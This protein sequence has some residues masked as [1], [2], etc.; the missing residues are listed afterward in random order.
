MKILH[1]CWG[2]EPTNGAANIA[3]M[4]MGEQRLAGHVVE[5]ASRWTREEIAG[6]DE[7]WCHC[8]WYWR[9]W[10]SVWIAKRLGKRIYWVPECCYDPIRLAHHG[11]KKRLAGPF[12][13]WAL[14]RA[15]VLVATCRAEGE[16]IRAYEPRVKKVE[17]S[18][19]RR[20]FK[21]GA[22]SGELLASRFSRQ[23]ADMIFDPR[24]HA[25]PFAGSQ[26]ITSGQENSQRHSPDLAP[27]NHESM[28]VLYLGRP[29][30]LKGTK[31]LEQ[32]VKELN[33]H[34]TTTT[35]NYNYILRMVSDHHG[36][37]LERDW[38]WCDV[39]C[40]PTLS[41]NFGLVVAEALSRGKRVITTDG[42]PAWEDQP[43]VIYLR[44]YRDGSDESRVKMLK[45]AL[46]ECLDSQSV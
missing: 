21:L 45:D 5:I 42:A 37:E 27:C 9:I 16:W 46:H 19:I 22:R 43:G 4:I 30:V 6:C 29:H 1:L 35:S 33:D 39:L 24:V 28:H 23:P 15:D 20:F 7:L 18:D 38:A 14:R 3:R 26:K 8:G 41:D 44:G 2:L 13:R 31:Y 40:L 32:A 12:E 34:S 17:V 25:R 11:W 10:L 36:E